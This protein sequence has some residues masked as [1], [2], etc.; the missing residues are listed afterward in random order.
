ME[1]PLPELGYDTGR[2]RGERRSRK[3]RLEQRRVGLIGAKE[4]R[5][6]VEPLRKYRPVDCSRP[7][8][9]ARGG[10]VL[11]Q[12]RRE[13]GLGDRGE[14]RRE[15]ADDVGAEMERAVARES[16]GN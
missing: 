9:R 13:F 5:D 1:T 6:E 4:T 12:Q 3:R 2:N 8:G 16:D 11:G 7:A 14:G 15:A 10:R